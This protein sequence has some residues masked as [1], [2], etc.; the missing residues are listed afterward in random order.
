MT[1]VIVVILWLIDVSPCFVLIPLR[2]STIGASKIVKII[3]YLFKFLKSWRNQTNVFDI[4][5]RHYKV[6]IM[7]SLTD[8]YLGV[9][10]PLLTWWCCCISEGVHQP[11]ARVENAVV[12]TARRT[13]HPTVIHL[14]LPISFTSS[15]ILSIL[16]DTASCWSLF[17]NFNSSINLPI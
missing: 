9:K 8:S 3:F 6:A 16:S 1:L 15:S 10:L 5:K 14:I 2:V 4:N 11:D 13:P 12:K 17:S 7:S